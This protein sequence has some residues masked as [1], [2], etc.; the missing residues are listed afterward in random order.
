MATFKDA[1][2][3]AASI[4]KA[5]NPISIVLFGSVAREGTGADLDLLVVTDDQAGSGQAFQADLVLHHSLKR[6]YKKFAIDPFVISLSSLNEYHAKGSPFL[7]QISREGRSLYMKEAV[8]EWLKQAADELKMAGYL[9]QGEFFKGACYHAQQCVEKA[10]KARLL[11]KGWTLEKTHSL[12]RLNAIGKDY[13]I[14]LNLTD[15]EI[16]FIDS[17]YRGRYPAEAG[18]L[19]LGEPLEEDAKKAVD[20]AGRLFKRVKTASKISRA[21]TRAAT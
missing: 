4:V 18:L 7:W 17:I 3:V 21:R 13:K 8:K 15:E 19:P 6:F 9:L 1:I 5:I 20:I 10:I 2:E 16:V 11:G 12:E 14:K